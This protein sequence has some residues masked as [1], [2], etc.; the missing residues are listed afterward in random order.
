MN[1]Y[2]AQEYLKWHDKSVAGR[3][4]K[5]VEPEHM[6]LDGSKL[7]AFLGFFEGIFQKLILYQRHV[8]LESKADEKSVEKNDDEDFMKKT[9][10]YNDLES[11]SLKRET[12]NSIHKQG[13]GV[14]DTHLPPKNSS[15]NNKFKDFKKMTD[16]V[17]SF[18][19]RNS[20]KLSWTSARA[21][22]GRQ[23]TSTCEKCALR[24]SHS[25]TKTQAWPT[26]ISITSMSQRSVVTGRTVHRRLT[27]ASAENSPRVLSCKGKDSSMQACET[28]TTHFHTLIQ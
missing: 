12:L 4:F 28:A 10:D 22:S 19:P 3:V 6:T 7:K 1:K 24:I 25:S 17:G 26:I 11:E 23:A 13:T 21:T 16:E 18:D 20:K 27:E 8:N 2:T 9:A 15:S 5:P 14:F